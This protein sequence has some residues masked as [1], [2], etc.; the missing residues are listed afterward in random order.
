MRC[1]GEKKERKEGEQELVR[2]K[3]VCLKRNSIRRKGKRKKKT[4]TKRIREIE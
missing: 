3:N 1:T 4:E 2:T